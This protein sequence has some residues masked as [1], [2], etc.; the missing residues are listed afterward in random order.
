MPC[1]YHSLVFSPSGSMKIGC[2]S[3][4]LKRTT[5]VLDRRAVAR[6]RTLDIARIY[7]RAVEIIQYDPVRFRRGVGQIA[8]RAVMQRRR[9]GHERKRHDRIVAV[10]RLHA[11]K[12]RWCGRPARAGVP[13]LKRRISKPRSSETFRQR[14]RRHQP[15][16]AAVPAAFAD[17]DARFQVHAGA[18]HRRAA[19][20][21][22]R[23]SWF[24]RRPRVRFLRTPA[25]SP[26]AA[27]SR[28]SQSSTARRMRV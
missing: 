12:N 21:R 5:F 4:S 10:L 25:V 24:P 18:D 23:R 3:L 22:A 9:I 6:A 17:D 16:R 11:A 8:A 14:V 1:A 13:V 26:P 2:R 7:R 15:L 28:C 19:A 27:A 20:I